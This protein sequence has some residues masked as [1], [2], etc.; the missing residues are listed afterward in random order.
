M[1]FIRP[2][3]CIL[4]TFIQRPG[5]VALKGD[6]LATLATET[7][8]NQA[9]H[10]SQTILHTEWEWF[11]P[12]LPHNGI[13]AVLSFLGVPKD[14]IKFFETFLRAPLRYKG[15]S[16]DELRT[17]VRGVPLGY[18]L[19]DL[20][21]DAVQFI[22][23]FAVNQRA[24]GLHLYPIQNDVWLWDANAD[25]CAHGW[26][27]MNRYAALLGLRFDESKTGAASIGKSNPDLP[28]GDI[29]WGLLKFDSSK[30]KFVIDQEEVD[31]HITELRHQLSTAKSVFGWVNVYNQYMA[32]LIR[33]FGGRPANCF[34]VEHVDDMIDTLARVQ[35]ELIPNT[36]GAV[37]GHLRAMIQERFG[38]GDLPEGY[39]YSP[40]ARGGLEVR[41][42]M[43]ELL[44]VRNKVHSKPETCFEREKKEDLDRYNE[45]KKKIEESAAEFAPKHGRPATMTSMSFEDYTAGR[46][47]D[48]WDWTRCYAHLLV[49]P[50]PS[51][52]SLTPYIKALLEGHAKATW[53]RMN[54]YERWILALYG[55]EVVR[56]LGSM[57]MVDRTMIPVAMVQHFRGARTKWDQ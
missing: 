27:E 42:P 14:W 24:D 41:N 53:S 51:C 31:K 48:L 21:V 17:R 57:E 8:L 23:H 2:R 46:T 7:Y 30:A 40:L 43:I 25:R 35:R 37:V 56:R 39:F 29:S 47:I 9:L 45:V 36:K 18:A 50:D 19:S 52:V 49:R 33:N 15:E 38:F 22:M 6:L 44:G 55:E 10:D 3:I 54:Y 13:L 16:T 5:S 4:I 26:K 34:G 1:L 32:F 28:S 11:G 12:S 20:C